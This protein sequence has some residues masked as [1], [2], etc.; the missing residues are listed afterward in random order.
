MKPPRRISLRGLLLVVTAASLGLGVP[1][2]LARK[3]LSD[4][5]AL[6]DRGATVRFWPNPPT[7]LRDLGLIDA[8]PFFVDV[9]VSVAVSWRF[10]KA[11]FRDLPDSEGLL[12]EDAE[13]LILELREAARDLGVDQYSLFVEYLD[14]AP[15]YES[16]FVWWDDTPERWRVFANQHS[17][18]I[19][20]AY[21]AVAPIKRESGPASAV[22]R[23][24]YDEERRRSTCAVLERQTP[25]YE[26]SR[27]DAS[28][29]RGGWR[30][31]SVHAV[32]ATRAER[33]AQRGP[34]DG[35]FAIRKSRGPRVV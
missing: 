15:M 25:S 12:R 8:S 10:G 26:A 3:R 19:E 35:G 6:R 32:F 7:W 30:R 33:V 20:I 18:P 21:E 28:V 24:L 14:M 23:S 16:A 29:R 27:P 9:D 22:I 31:D 4:L 1:F 17:I 5:D 13:R 34:I 2:G 11:R